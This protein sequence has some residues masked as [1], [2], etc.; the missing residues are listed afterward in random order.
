MANKRQIPKTQESI[1][2]VIYALAKIT[3][4]LVKAYNGNGAAAQ[5]ARVATV[6]I[7][8][9]LKKFREVSIKEM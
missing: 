2:E 6:K 7:F 8:P 5:R 1:T 3:D 4:D 9:V